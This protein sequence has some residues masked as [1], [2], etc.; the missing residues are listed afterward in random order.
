M[1]W[2]QDNTHVLLAFQAP[3]SGR[4]QDVTVEA[5]SSTLS[6]VSN[7]YQMCSSSLGGEIVPSSISVVVKYPLALLRA[8]KAYPG[9]MWAG[10][11][12]PSS[13]DATVFYPVL[14]CYKAF[15]TYETTDEGYH[16]FVTGDRVRVLNQD[17]PSGWWV[18]EKSGLVGLIPSNLFQPDSP[19]DPVFFEADDPG[20][21][22]C[23]ISAQP[24]PQ[25]EPVAQE[26]EPAAEQTQEG[27][28]YDAQAQIPRIENLILG[29]TQLKATCGY[30]D[31]SAGELVFQEGDVVTVL[32]VSED[33]WWQAQLGD[34]VGAI[35]SNFFVEYKPPPP[36]PLE[37]RRP[38]PPPS[39]SAA[40]SY[41]TI[42]GTSHT[43]FGGSSVLDS[44]L[45]R[46]GGQTQTLRHASRTRGPKKRPP[47][48]VHEKP[49]IETW[50]STT[51][52]PT[53]DTSR[54][55]PDEEEEGGES[56]G[57][58]GGR[59]GQRG[60]PPRS[61][62]PTGPVLPAVGR[63]GGAPALRHVDRN[64]H[65][66]V[67]VAFG[68]GPV[69]QEQQRQPPQ[70]PIGPGM[71][72]KTPG[73]QGGQKQGPRPMPQGQQQ[74]QQ[75]PGPKPPV[76]KAAPPPPPKQQQQPQQQ[77]PQQQ[78]QQPQQ[79]PQARPGPA[80]PKPGMKGP[81]PAGGAGPRP[82]PK[83][84]GA[85]VGA[86]SLSKVPSGMEEAVS[87]GQ[88]MAGGP[89]GFAAS[90]GS[91]S[92][93]SHGRSGLVASQGV[94]WPVLYAKYSSSMGGA[95][96][97]RVGKT[98]GSIL[99]AGQACK[100]KRNVTE[101]IDE[102]S[103]LLTEVVGEPVSCDMGHWM[104][105][106]STEDSVWGTAHSLRAS[107]VL[108]SDVDIKDVVEVYCYVMSC[109]VSAA[110]AARIGAVLSGSRRAGGPEF[111]GESAVKAY[112]TNEGNGAVWT[113]GG[114]GVV[115]AGKTGG[116]GLVGPAG[117]QSSIKDMASQVA[118]KVAC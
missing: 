86:A 8:D 38:A 75:Q 56:A 33:G 109:L 100:G 81:S 25:P 43:S 63:G 31:E 4:P 87:T 94:F 17:D 14:G 12:D 64:Q 88:K 98:E 58:R 46:R 15:N 102:I 36:A 85:S 118:A 6:V 65:R 82:G 23:P 59:G 19:D 2:E 27:G 105:L 11:F 69:L 117:D 112:F 60:L 107:G 57:P 32:S 35:P 76:K 16:S 95:M 51:A 50:E 80:G 42:A 9:Q 115:V 49:R 90:F 22:F 61:F 21:I 37:P 99:L 55:A 47:T 83:P 20:N 103:S 92:I 3:E 84:R 106:L 45:E 101:A 41:A 44:A 104:K 30:G 28:D 1:F 67:T 113:T 111:S 40:S 72:R 96:S 29:V 89:R 73:P 108:P 54:S 74:G 10:F 7:G 62:V 26:P 48:N 34:R 91:N 97:G 77:Q 114:V 66:P 79:T 68:H 116:M 52:S 39:A 71:L 70:Q 13:Q 78:Q 53:A 24:E 18:A 93:V 5:T 110:G